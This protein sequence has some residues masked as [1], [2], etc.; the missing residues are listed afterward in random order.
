[1]TIWEWIHEFERS[2]AA[3]GDRERMLLAQLHGEAYAHRQHDPDRMLALMEEGRRLAVKLNEPWWVLFYEHWKVETL[4]YYKDDY[5]AV[6]DLAVKSTLELR[7]PIFEHYP[8]RFGIYCNLVAA[9]LCVDPRGHADSIRS[10]LDYLAVQVE[11]GSGDR[12]LLQARRHWFAYEMGQ[13]EEARALALEELAL[14]S[15]DPDQH[16]ARHHEVDTYK[17]LCWIDFRRGDWQ[18]LA[19]HAAAGEE[20][21][22][23][24]EYHYEL[25][26]F[27]L[28]QAVCERRLGNEDRA[29]RLA[30][31]GQ[32]EMKRLGQPPGESYYDALATFHE[33]AGDYDSAWRERCGELSNTVGKGQLAYE[34]L[35]RLKRVRLLKKRNQPTEQEAGLA[36]EAASKLR[37]PAW[38]L[39][40][41]RRILG[42]EENTTDRRI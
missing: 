18:G 33:L 40:E 42:G 12:Y 10:A 22:A 14:A 38:Y 13:L 39:E 34:C 19:G 2:V 29:R 3:A 27:L 32:A 24:L 11:P 17:A 30:R 20:Q 5:R 4:I 23:A 8:L 35:V 28:W 37:A 41:L 16:T 26:L 1:M 21:S 7:K 6:I 15:S 25:A 36:R 9:Y 31:R